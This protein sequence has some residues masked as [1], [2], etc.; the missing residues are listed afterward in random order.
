MSQEASVKSS[1]QSQVISLATLPNLNLQQLTMFKQQLDQELGVFQD[2]LHTLKIAQSRFQESGSC[3][4]KITPNT[5]GSE[6]L[7]PLTGSMYVTGKLAD[8][9]NVIV[10]IGT[11][12]YAEK[13]VV[14]AKDYFKRKVEYV[15]EQMEK[16]QQVGIER[17]KLRE[18][19]M[20]IIEARIQPPAWD[21]RGKR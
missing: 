7:V 17:T 6:I 11:G 1:P 5:E 9:N 3:L 2:S 15:T 19:T 10:D 21:A 12:Y 16:I 18:A 8:A 13:S 20:D 4:E 14:D